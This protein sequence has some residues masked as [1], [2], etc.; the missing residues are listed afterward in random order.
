CGIA[1]DADGILFVGDRSGSILRVGDGKTSV[2]ASIPPSIAAFHLAFGPDGALFVTGPTLNTRDAIYRVSPTGAVEVFY[3]GFGRPQGMAFD[4]AGR[5][6]VA[7]AI[8]GTG[9]L[10]R[11]AAD[12]GEPELLVAAGG[13]VGLAFSP[14]GA[15]AVASGDTVY[16]FNL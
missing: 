7:D 2:V 5:L 9:G 14:D 6:Y 15:L 13:L 3:G 11:F 10:Y 16:R 8:A 1:F 4:E 12:G